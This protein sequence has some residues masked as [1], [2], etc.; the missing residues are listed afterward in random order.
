MESAFEGVDRIFVITD[1]NV[2]SIYRSAFGP[3]EVLAVPPGEASKS[4]EQFGKC[5]DW[6]VAKGARR[7]SLL[8]AVGGGVVGDLVGFVAATYMRGI[9]YIQVPTS[10]IA[11]V[12]SSVGGKVA[13]DLPSAKNIVGS[14]YP[15]SRVTVDVRTLRTLPRE[16][17]IGGTAEVWKYALGLDKELFQQL[18]GSPLDQNADVAAVVRRCIEIK[19][20]VVQED[21]FERTGSRARLNVGHTVGHAIEQVTNYETSHGNAVAIGM[22]VETKLGER[23]GWTTRGTSDAVE[24][25]LRMQGLPVRHPVLAQPER[26]LA[27]MANDKKRGGEGLAF[28]LI[29]EI[30]TSKLV[31][32]LSATEVSGILRDL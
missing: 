11:Q 5:L 9:R 27:A 24:H 12:D 22:V 17:F 23:L 32:G 29:Q 21:E 1:S 30:G 7:D 3:A 25:V 19:A 6:L 2:E 20:A 31:D 8:F 4:L 14:F 18:S 15:P 28:A 13:V 10:L 16:E 26:L